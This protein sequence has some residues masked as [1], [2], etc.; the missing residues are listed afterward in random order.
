MG[1]QSH[2]SNTDV[3]KTS[4]HILLWKK[5]SKPL[6]CAETTVWQVA[7]CNSVLA[8]GIWSDLVSKSQP[9]LPVSI[10]RDWDE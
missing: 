6:R 1:D 9:R 2:I 7:H 4:F 3:E 8:L 5:L 10:V